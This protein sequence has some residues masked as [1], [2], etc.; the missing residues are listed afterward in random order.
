MGVR[1]RRIHVFFCSRAIARSN[2][3]SFLQRNQS[4]VCGIFM[5]SF[6]S[7]FMFSFRHANKFP[8][9][10]T[11]MMF[12]RIRKWRKILWNFREKWSK[13]D[14]LLAS[15]L[16]VCV[17]FVNN[18]NS[19]VVFHPRNEWTIKLFSTLF[20]R[21]GA[22][23][24]VHLMY[25]SIAM[26]VNEV[27]F[28]GVFYIDAQFVQI[29]FWHWI[30]NVMPQDI[31]L[32]HTITFQI[33]FVSNFRPNIL[34]NVQFVLANQSNRANIHEHVYHFIEIAHRFVHTQK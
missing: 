27:N 6:N 4:N 28:M 12:V 22:F 1:I 20:F 33:C 17:H 5:F 13:F 29:E 7:I 10:I 25:S 23:Y 11:E 34:S 8:H 32:S 18:P 9:E 24:S 31:L 21:V 19:S 3:R 2:L 26:D 15:V 14:G 16:C 30:G